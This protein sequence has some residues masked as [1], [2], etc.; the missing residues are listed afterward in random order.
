MTKSRLSDLVGDVL[1]GFEA[2]RFVVEEK[3]LEDGGEWVRIVPTNP[4]AAVIE[5]TV[6]GSHALLDVGDGAVLDYF[7]G[8]PEELY[9]AL[10]TDLRAIVEGRF[11]IVRY[12][13]RKRLV[14]VES[15][16][17]GRKATTHFKNPLL[18]WFPCGQQRVRYAP[19]DSS[20]R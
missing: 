10:R 2:S 15:Y 11:E 14:K 9:S 20:S 6:H 17:A 4:S 12:E 8:H 13:W 7:A 18:A 16:I 1:A 19:Y 3:T 5:G